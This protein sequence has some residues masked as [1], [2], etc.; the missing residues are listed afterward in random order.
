[1]RG[2]CLSSSCLFFLSFF[3]PNLLIGQSFQDIAPAQGITHGYGISASNTGG[4]VSFYDFTGNG[5]DDLSFTTQDGE[6]LL[7]LQNQGGT[8]TP[9]SLEGINHKGNSQ[10]LLWT[11]YDNDG[12]PD[13][14]ITDTKGP[15]ILYQNQGELQFID[16]T[17]ASELP[18]AIN[19]SYAACW[20]D[21]DRDG[22]L[23]L[24]VTHYGPD[25]SSFVNH[26]YHN[27]GNGIFTDV[28]SI[29][30]V[31]D[32]AKPAL[33]VMFTDI[34]KDF[35]PDIYIANDHQY[36]N[37][38]F[39]NNGDGTFTDISKNSG[40]GIPMD[41]MGIT[42]GDYDLDGDLD[43][44]VSNTPQ[45]N[46]LFRNDNNDSFTDIAAA[47]GVALHGIGWGVNFIDYDND[48]DQDI[49]ASSL[50]FSNNPTLTT[51]TLFANQGGGFFIKAPGAGFL[52]DQ[53][54]SYGNAIGDLNQDG[55][56]DIAVNNSDP[57]TFQIWK[58]SGGSNE[59]ISV[60]LEGNESNKDGVGSWIELVAGGVR[61]IHFTHCGTSFLSQN[62]SRVIFGLKNTQMV[63]SLI[64]SWPS[65]KVDVLTNLSSGQ[66]LTVQEGSSPAEPTSIDL[67][68]LRQM[69]RVSPNPTSDMVWV[70]W[71]GSH[72]SHLQVQLLTLQGQ[73]IQ[74]HTFFPTN[75]TR[76]EVI[77]VQGLTPGIYV[78][79]ISVPDQGRII[80][81]LEVR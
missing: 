59:W 9:I 16:V 40:A 55:Y 36:G 22:W 73:R 38:L 77:S 81:K 52:G 48:I 43:L 76:Q 11:D 8:F 33:A 45:G 53:A 39:R 7:F 12:D 50:Y 60:K 49:Y 78:L 65:G 58:N 74:G 61:Q 42:T 72:T 18:N 62:S 29:A 24:Y 10:Q 32:S 30:S 1:M 41:A 21:Y 4:G 80:E 27:E 51:S 56:Y 28:T 63:D 35:Y 19:P 26:L 6:P 14:F 5:W 64:I 75:G 79:E 31:A 46:A 13:L 67:E 2:T 70:E 37:T 17:T 25:D 34:N 44:Y 20:G 71:L 69:I 57:D 3:I 47:A 54:K 23:D 15:N 66:A 68:I